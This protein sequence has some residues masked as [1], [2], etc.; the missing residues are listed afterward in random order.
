MLVADRMVRPERPLVVSEIFGPTVQGEGPNSGVPCMFLR[1]SNCNLDCHW[2]DTPYTWNWDVYDKEQEQSYLAWREAFERLYKPEV[3]HIV[4]SG[5]EP[6]LQQEALKPLV[7]ELVSCGYTVEFETNGTIPPQDWLGDLAEF[8][9]SPKLP[10]ART[11]ANPIRPIGMERFAEMA[12]RS[13]TVRFKW[14]CATAEDV[15]RVRDLTTEWK[16]PTDAT[17]VMPLGTNPEKVAESLSVI[18]D[19]AVEAGFHL[20]SRLHV[21]LWG[22]ERGH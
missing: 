8:S 3:A 2:C 21:Y 1:L 14:V 15:Q 19:P 5:G 6:L 20:T 12:W 22:G 11:T 4:I 18:S 7:L 17:W 10:H 16:I 9:V 13:D